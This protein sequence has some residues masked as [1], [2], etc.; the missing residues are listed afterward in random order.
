MVFGSTRTPNIK[1]VKESDVNMAYLYKCNNCGFV[2]IMWSVQSHLMRNP[3]CRNNEEIGV[4]DKVGGKL[5]GI[6]DISKYVVKI[7]EED[8]E[9]ELK[10]KAEAAAEAEA[11][12]IKE[13]EKQK[14]E[15]EPGHEQVLG[16]DS[17]LTEPDV[18]ESEKVKK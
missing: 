1:K 16:F 10:K 5:L 7:K 17:T 2:D 15:Q 8:Y 13:S 12:L 3:D 9:Q 6:K 4:Y 14:P 11:K 18:K